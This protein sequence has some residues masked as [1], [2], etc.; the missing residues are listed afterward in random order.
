MKKYIFLLLIFIPMVLFAQASNNVDLYRDLLVAHINQYRV[1]MGLPELEYDLKL[2]NL[3][4]AF[5][6]KLA[7]NKIADHE[8]I[9]TDEFVKV[10]LANGIEPG[11]AHEIIQ[12]IPNDVTPF[13]V[14]YNFWASPD[15]KKAMEYYYAEKIGGAVFNDGELYYILFYIY[16]E[17]VRYE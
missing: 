10:A 14:F 9:G 7:I 1:S 17:G 5:V 11:I 3:A 2:N 4:A 6:Q 15:H 16:E 13:N 8:F 12:I